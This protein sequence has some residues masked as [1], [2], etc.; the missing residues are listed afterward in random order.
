LIQ[1]GSLLFGGTLPSAPNITLASGGDITANKFNE[2]EIKKVS[3]NYGIGL[4]NYTVPLTGINNIAFGTNN[5]KLLTSGG[6]N[7]TIGNAAGNKLTEGDSNV[8]VGTLSLSESTTANNNV[9]IGVKSL[10][11]N[12]IGGANVTIGSQAGFYIEG[13]RNTILGAY[14][15]T[16]A[17]STL[18]DTVIISAGTVE[19]L[20]ID[21]TGSL[22]LFGGTLPSAPNITLNG[23]DGSAQLRGSGELLLG[24]TLPSAPNIILDGIDGSAEFDG[25]ITCTDNSK[26]LD[27]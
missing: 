18:N 8:A 4:S 12:V 21:S 6:G 2:V 25:D 17:D 11:S 9:A 15:G 20:R 14:K 23:S 26:G 27:P 24:G 10:L 3:S 5:L 22:L 19:K 13:S 16:E 7:I 1:L